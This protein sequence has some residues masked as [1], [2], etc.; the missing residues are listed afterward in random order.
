MK[1]NGTKK[2]ISALV[3]SVMLAAMMAGCGGSRNADNA[4]T[5]QTAQTST[6][7][8]P[9]QSAPPEQVEITF[10]HCWNGGGG[11]FPQ[12][13]ENNP[14][15]KVIK[16]KT[17][18]TLK[19]ESI[20]TNE[21]EKLNTMFA[22][23]VV[24]DFVNFPF[25]SST[26]S[27][28][29][30]VTKAAAE[31]QLL[32]IDPYLDKYPN[33]KKLTEVG[34]A[35]DFYQYDLHNAD[36]KGK[37]YLIPQQTP[38]GTKESI[39]NWMYGVYARGDILKA[40]NVKAE[41]IKTSDQLY[42]LLVKIKNGGFKDA[43]GKPVIPAGTLHDG[44]WYQGY[45]QFWTDYNISNWR[46]EDGKV[47][48]Y[49]LSKDEDP[50]MLF[51]R[52]LIKDGLFDL[53][54][55]SNTDTMAK[56]KLAVGKL[57][58]FGGQSSADDLYNTL[59]KTNPE[60]QYEL[61]GPFLNKSGNICAQVEQKGRNGFPAMFISAQCKNPDAVFRFLDYVNSDEGHL[62]A[63]YGIE[64]THYTMENG[65]PKIIPELKAK[66]DAEGNLKR[67]EGL[68]YLQNFIGAFSQ[69]VTWPMPDEEKRPAQLLMET[70]QKKIPIEVIDK[71]D[72]GYLALDWPKAEDYKKAVAQL[73]YEGTLKKAFFSKT[74]EEALKM[75]SEIR[76]KLVAAG[77][78]E[79]GD[80]I[81]E[82]AA[83]RDDIGF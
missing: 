77:L 62:L 30:V 45:V 61:L 72:A 51:I 73:D 70:Y 17:G 47:V 46:Q 49:M 4:I 6:A 64:G 71:V 80:W 52:K 24:P 23:G 42:D 79:R 25:W 69:N 41:D 37:S 10:L 18:V 5:G 50:K 81:A 68:V 60:M 83:G 33:V 28:G 40:L 53:E 74:D 43:N 13:Q 16:E 63:Y 19:M 58:T 34:I 11:A 82:K 22:S 8:E 55:F 66:W 31:D 27:E 75:M 29:A 12:D 57:A 26:S 15:A 44:F 35:K 3:V 9:T 7:G 65:R 59:Y 36:F 1:S 78:Q 20:T 21:T 56:E 32:C 2:I 39:T 48:S 67:D 38:D 76:A 14:I 54:A